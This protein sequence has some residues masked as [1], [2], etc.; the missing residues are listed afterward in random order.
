MHHHAKQNHDVHTRSSESYASQ[1]PGITTFSQPPSFFGRNAL[2]QPFSISAVGMPPS[3]FK[4]ECLAFLPSTVSKKHP[5]QHELVSL[6]CPSAK[7]EYQNPPVFL[8]M[9]M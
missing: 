3:C 4:S 5:I 6:H 2:V 1:L 7:V 9:P 8:G